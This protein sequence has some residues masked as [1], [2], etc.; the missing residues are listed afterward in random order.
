MDRARAANQVRAAV[1]FLEREVLE[2]ISLLHNKH[3]AALILSPTMT[4]GQETCWAHKTN[5]EHQTGRQANR[6]APEETEWD[7]WAQVGW[8]QAA[9]RQCA[10]MPRH[11]RTTWH[12][13]RRTQTESTARTAHDTTVSEVRQ[14]RGGLSSRSE[15]SSHH[16][17]PWVRSPR[18]RR[19]EP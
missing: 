15:Q 17:K 3:K 10:D 11:H 6:S 18:L 16:M 1:K 12:I 9:S 7:S 19:Q 4:L 5:P 14:V 8:L 2:F 13:L